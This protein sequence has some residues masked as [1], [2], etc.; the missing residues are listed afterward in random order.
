MNIGLKEKQ[1]QKDDK[2]VENLDLTLKSICDWIFGERLLRQ[3]GENE[4]IE[5]EDRNMNVWI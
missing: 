5:Q 2:N 3:D 1:L 4:E